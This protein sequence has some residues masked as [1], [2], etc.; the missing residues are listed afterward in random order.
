MHEYIDCIAV[1]K[2][3][4]GWKRPRSERLAFLHYF[5][6]LHFRRSTPLSVDTKKCDKEKWPFF[7][8]WWIHNAATA[9]LQQ[10]CR[11]EIGERVSHQYFLCLPGTVQ[12][13]WELQVLKIDNC[14]S[15]VL[16]IS[17][18]FRLAAEKDRK[19]F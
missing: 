12:P 10:K 17:K 14:I 13:I 1:I 5:G 4:F 6:R 2:G 18:I 15:E 8:S 11:V 7:S 19:A 16:W 3:F 9:T